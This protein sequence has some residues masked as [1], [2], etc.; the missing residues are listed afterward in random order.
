MASHLNSM[1]NG[2]KTETKRETESCRKSNSAKF[3]EPPEPPDEVVDC[4]TSGVQ[5]L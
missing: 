1:L 2:S 4:K 3:G 5:T